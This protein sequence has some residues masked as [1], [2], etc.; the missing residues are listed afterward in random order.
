MCQTTPGSANPED[1]KALSTTFVSQTC[2][3]RRLRLLS[4]KTSKEQ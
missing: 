4:V 3:E 2:M 1:G